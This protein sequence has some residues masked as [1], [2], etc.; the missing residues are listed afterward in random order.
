MTFGIVLLVAG[1]LWLLIALDVVDLAWQTAL[2][3]G[4]ILVGVAILAVGRHG[5]LI[6]LGVTLTVLL[7]LAAMINVP[8]EGGIGERTHAPSSALDLRDE[9]RLAMGKMTVDL[10]ALDPGQLTGDLIATV[11]M[12]E[13]RVL[14]PPGLG[15]VV[16]G[17]AGAGEVLLLGDR[18]AGVGVSNVAR[19][20]GDGALQLVVEVGFGKVEVR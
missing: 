12:G 4:L 19:A 9:Y 16:E 1:A 7:A 2:A 20:E 5:G 18:E 13:L 14:L 15:V 17:E 8:L 10:S 11:G 3:I 6:A